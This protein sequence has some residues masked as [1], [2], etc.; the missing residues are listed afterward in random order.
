MNIDDYERFGQ[1]RY[2]RLAQV[3]EEILHHALLELDGVANV[4]QTQ[5]RAKDPAALRRKLAARGLNG[6]NG[7]EDEIKDLAGCRII[8]YTATDLERFQQS[9]VWRENFDIEWSASKIRK[10]IRPLLLVVCEAVLATEMTE[11]EATSFDTVTFSRATLRADKSLIEAR[12]NSISMVM[13][14]LEASVTGA[15]WIQSWNCLWSGTSA[16]NRGGAGDAD[17]RRL[18]LDLIQRLA[19]TI[20]RNQNRIPNDVLQEIEE[21]FYWAHRR[22]AP[23][24]ESDSGV[25]DADTPEALARLSLRACRD[26]L[27]SDARYLAYKTLVGFRT[28]FIEEWDGDVDVEAKEELRRERISHCAALITRETLDEWVATVTQCATTESN[29]MAT[30]PPLTQFFD[31]LSN[32]SPD[33]ALMLLLESG[34]P[35]QRFAPAF[36]PTLVNTTARDDAL[37]TMNEWVISGKDP[38]ALARALF[39]CDESF[40]Q[41]IENIGSHVVAEKNEMGCLEAAHA[42]LKHE[43]AENALLTK[44]FVPAL[45][46]LTSVKHGYMCNSY[47]IRGTIEAKL[48]E[49]PLIAAEALIRNCVY[50]TRIGYAQQKKL[51]RLARNHS[52]LVWD[53]FQSRIT[54]AAAREWEDPY[55]A[56]PDDWHGLEKQLRGDV[57]GV[58]KRICS[59]PVCSDREVFH[60]KAKFLACLYHDCDQAFVDGTI[61]LIEA[62]GV[63]IIPFICEVLENFDGSVLVYPI[64]QAMIQVCAEEDPILS[65]IG[66]AIEKNGVVSGEFGMAEAYERKAKLLRDWLSH[67]DLKVRNFADS[68]ITEFDNRALD[69]RRRGI[70]RR[71]RRRRDFDDHV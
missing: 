14:A 3:V 1:S 30:F 10:S 63:A 60:D 11:S 28:V 51:E 33:L 39:L 35:L 2:A 12:E 43:T 44:V 19:E 71:E 56:I 47:L 41:L 36:F 55:E 64:C 8:F 62:E 16:I 65:Q 69:E 57:V 21:A 23:H 6:C 7:I 50:C 15:E 48:D 70:E 59:W 5:N 31:Q 54:E 18:Q 38:A 67:A 42:A 68:L 40:S 24:S 17:L 20:T 22:L 58:L 49:L 66:W 29:D 61:A 25:L 4:P 26:T 45:D 13:E 53:M 52:E 27:N 9:S 37:K 34:K 46:V 32:R